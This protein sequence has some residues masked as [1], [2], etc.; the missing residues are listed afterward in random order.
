MQELRAPTRSAETIDQLR[1]AAS[2]SLR[3]AGIATAR[4]DADVLLAAACGIDRAQLY[5]HGS[6]SVAESF[7]ADFR[8]M[9]ARRLAHEPLAYI[10]GR[11]EFWSLDFLVTP[12]VLIPRPETELLV[13]LAL[14]LPFRELDD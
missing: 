8:A 7:A 1:V 10:T 3:A 2:A 12:D 13:E 14:S 9:L 5:A 6:D 11:Q 4:L